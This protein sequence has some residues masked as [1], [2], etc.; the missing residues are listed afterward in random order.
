MV[1]TQWGDM[2]AFRVP[3]VSVMGVNGLSV[4]KHLPFLPFLTGELFHGPKAFDLSSRIGIMW[5]KIG[6]M[7]DTR[8]AL[9]PP[10]N[11]KISVNVPACNL[12]IYGFQERV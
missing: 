7:P 8:T 6:Y 5:G 3:L 10:I 9:F 1:L 4:V 11:F 12:A 2:V